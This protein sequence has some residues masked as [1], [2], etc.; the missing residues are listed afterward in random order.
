[1][2]KQKTAIGTTSSFS[3]TRGLDQQSIEVIA[4]ARMDQTECLTPPPR[5]PSRRPRKRAKVRFSDP[6]PE[7]EREWNRGPDASTGLTP[8]VSRTVIRDEVNSSTSSAF[9]SITGRSEEHTSEL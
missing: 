7:M 2:P 8:A 1:M 4:V 3:S 5:T 9:E 6:G